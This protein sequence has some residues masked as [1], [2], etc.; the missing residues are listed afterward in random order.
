MGAEHFRSDLPSCP[1]PTLVPGS[2]AEPQGSWPSLR[3]RVIAQPDP[4]NVVPIESPAAPSSPSSCLSG[5]FKL[6][7]QQEAYVRA[8]EKLSRYFWPVSW[9]TDF[10]DASIGSWIDTNSRH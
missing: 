8:V 4:D 6:R 2:P 9:P 7:Y 10:W 3:G 1:T 5:R